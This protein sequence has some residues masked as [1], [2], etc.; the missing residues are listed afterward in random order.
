MLITATGSRSAT[1]MEMVRGQ[2]TP[3]LDVGYPRIFRNLLAN[4]AKAETQ[5][6][7]SFLYSCQSYYILDG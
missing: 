5:H 1:S 6:S 2:I 3:Y 7:V 4:A